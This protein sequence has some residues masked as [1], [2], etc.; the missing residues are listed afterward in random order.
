MKKTLS[1]F[2]SFSL[3]LI[4][5]VNCGK[6]EKKKTETISNITTSQ[7]ADPSVSAEM[8]GQ[9][10]EGV[11]SNLGYQTYIIKPEEEIFFGDP[12]AVKGGAINYI[13]T[14]FPRTMRIYG[15]N[16][17]NV[18]YTPAGSSTADT[19]IKGTQNS[20]FSNVAN[21]KLNLW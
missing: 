17:G 16:S 5:A 20:G 15:Q 6:S 3:F 18:G 10:F 14:L 9:G 12:R 7:G 13:H 21:R 1:L 8:G 19:S 2:I 11:A 4:L